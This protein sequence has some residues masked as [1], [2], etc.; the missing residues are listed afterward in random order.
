MTRIIINDSEIDDALQL[1]KQKILN[2]IA[3]WISEGSGW[4]IESINNYFLN[5][6]KYRP[7]KGSSYMELPKELRNSA[8][9]L[10]NLK[11][12]DNECFK[13]CHIRHLN[14]QD[15]KPQRIKKSDRQ[16]INNLDYT[17]I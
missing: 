11:N 9:G 14:P 3:K 5:I 8:K 17:G 7:L 10:I 13:W 15:E 4:T 16:Y 12:N 6:V 1:S 2:L